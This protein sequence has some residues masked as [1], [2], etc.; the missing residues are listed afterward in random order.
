MRELHPFEFWSKA[1]RNAKKHDIKLGKVF[2][3]SGPGDFDWALIHIDFK[4]K[5]V[6]NN[7]LLNKHLPY[8]GSGYKS[9]V[10]IPMLS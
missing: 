9:R 8:T 10:R 7:D 5:N 2:A 1:L 4:A 6:N 3:T